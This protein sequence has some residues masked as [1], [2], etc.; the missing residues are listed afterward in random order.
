MERKSHHF[1]LPQ[2]GS[3]AKVFGNSKYPNMKKLLLQ[4]IALCALMFPIAQ[5]EAA[6]PGGLKPGTTFKLTVTTRSSIKVA[7]FETDMHAPIPS[8]IPNFKKG[9]LVRF[10]I[11]SNGQ[12]KADQMSIPIVRSDSLSNIYYSKR[13]TN[14]STI[15]SNGQLVKRRKIIPKTLVLS[16][17]KTSGSGF[18]TEVQ[19]VDYVLE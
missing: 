4:T 1:N 6:T 9:Q 18:Q 5:S 16:F 8:G 3:A 10:T 15:L 11:G 2:R 7:Q 13:A 14:L 12:L 19:T 17:A